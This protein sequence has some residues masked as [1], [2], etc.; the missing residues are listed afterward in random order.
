M[1]EVAA[2][3]KKMKNIKPQACQASVRNYTIHRG[4]SNSVDTGFM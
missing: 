4:Y 3:L 2:A 1:D